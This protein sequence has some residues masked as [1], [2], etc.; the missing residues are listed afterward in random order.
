MVSSLSDNYV[1]ANFSHRQPPKTKRK[2]AL[3]NKYAQIL[4]A[5]RINCNADDASVLYDTLTNIT[6]DAEG[7]ISVLPK[8]KGHEKWILSVMG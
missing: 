8:T 2:P 4:L 1:T 6:V 7:L 5:L 3:Y